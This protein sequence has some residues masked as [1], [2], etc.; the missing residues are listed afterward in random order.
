MAIKRI[1]DAMGR[2]R[3]KPVSTLLALAWLVGFAAW[4]HSFGMPNNPG[5]QRLMLWVRLPFDLLDLIDPP[6]ETGALPWSWLNLLQLVPFALIA[7]AIWIGAW[8]IGSLLLR[9]LRI[10]FDDCEQF[11]F[12]TTL[13]MSSVSL[14]M[15]V[16]GLS[17][18][19]SRWPFAIT[20]F[21]VVIAEVICRCRTGISLEAPKPLGRRFGLPQLSRLGWIVVIGLTPFVLGQLIGAM[22]PQNDFDVVEYH[23][24]GPKEWF[25]QGRI[26]RL[27]HNVYTSFPFLTEMLILSGMVLYGDWQWGA[28]AGQ[29]AIAG[30]A[31][32]TAIGL[33]AA[34]RRWFTEPTGWLAVAVYLT[35][36]WTYRFTIIAYAEG[37]LS[38]YLFAAI[39]A[40]L[41]FRD[42]FLNETSQPKPNLSAFAFLTGLLSGSAMACKYTG[43]VLVVIPIGILLI[44][45]V[46]YRHRFPLHQVLVKV[47][48]VFGLGIT[49]SVGPWLLKNTVETGNPVFPLAV[50]IF[51]GKDW[52]A[53]LDAKFRRGH[54]NRYGSWDDGL[55]DLP[56][57]LTDVVANN[58]WHSPL[59]FGLA[60]LS[61]LVL[62]RRRDSA[63]ASR[64]DSRTQSPLIAILWLYVGWQFFIWWG[65]THHIDRFYIPIFSAVALLAGIGARWL[66]ATPT[67][68]STEPCSTIWNWSSNFV[69]I[70]S[71]LY[72]ANLMQHGICGFNAGRLDLYSARD[73]ATV[74]R[75]K[76]LNDEIES[77]RLSS[78]TKVLHVGEVQLFHAR[79]PYLY[80]TVFDRSLFEKLCK[81]PNSS[82]QQLRPAAE[83][84]AEFRRLGITH[85]DVSWDWIIRYR[86]PGNYG[87]SDFVTPQHFAELM[88]MGILGPP[89]KLPGMAFSTAPLSEKM[90]QQLIDLDWAQSLVTNVAG[91]PS[92]FTAQI[93]PVIDS[94]DFRSEPDS[95]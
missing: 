59:M 42:Q 87:Y 4:F 30:F 56:T 83:I 89:L 28:L 35:S 64:S 17:G 45:I 46:T 95:R 29:A 58:D 57:K 73:I 53:D 19:L 41:L 48:L 40:A 2:D 70:G 12:S 37:G 85:I 32:L 82:D 79:Y 77:G 60:P 33:F 15:L 6:V 92:Y 71:V 1:V 62:L 23:L 72:S 7:V 55:K 20:L 69:V 49:C 25:Q 9:A 63:V 50:Q 78:H 66:E 54:A 5:V 94:D 88:Q 39:Y 76:W 26:S 51:G 34:G 36:P 75:I 38:C 11:F 8:G 43:F 86:E 3:L 21:V 81:L 68:S 24:G 22:T 27:S 14:A 44:W 65:F 84:R 91:E 18:H 31:P 80:N 16:L 90:H 13:G 52:D 93:F 10:R 67:D 74:P 47:V 61:L